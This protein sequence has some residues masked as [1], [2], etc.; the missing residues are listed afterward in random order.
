MSASSY[1]ESSRQGQQMIYSHQVGFGKRDEVA[2]TI[3]S[4]GW[5]GAIG[6]FAQRRRY[7]DPDGGPVR[8][9][10]MRLLVGSERRELDVGVLLG[11]S[12]IPSGDVA[13]ELGIVAAKDDSGSSR[14]WLLGPYRF[15]NVDDIVYPKK[16]T[17]RRNGSDVRVPDIDWR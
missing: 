16:I 17:F 5:A 6:D 10:V 11:C 4:T 1:L 13:G 14:N 12:E 3:F 2:V 9:L 8:I 7:L 15:M